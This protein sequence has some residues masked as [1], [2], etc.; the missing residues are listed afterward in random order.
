MHLRAWETPLTSTLSIYIL[1]DFRGFHHLHI[2][3]KR[4][5]L[6]SSWNPANF[7]RWSISVG[8]VGPPPIKQLRFLSRFTL[9]SEMAKKSMKNAEFRGSAEDF[10]ACRSSDTVLSPGQA[11]VT[12]EEFYRFV[13]WQCADILVLLHSCAHLWRDVI[14]RIQ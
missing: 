8:R 14:K 7:D 9:I 5:S 4:I 11:V 12:C 10:T 2:I 6:L 13:C 1:I 3:L